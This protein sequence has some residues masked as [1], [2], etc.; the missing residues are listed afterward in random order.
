M[1]FV[2]RFLVDISKV[3]RILSVNC[4]FYPF[5]NGII[6]FEIPTITLNFS[7]SNFEF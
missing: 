7:F 2:A 4:G 6:F 3:L 5:R 1:M